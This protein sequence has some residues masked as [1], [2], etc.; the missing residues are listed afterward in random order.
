MQDVT[1]N[2]YSLYKCG[3]PVPVLYGM[4][5]FGTMR[6]NPILAVDLLGKQTDKK[7]IG[8]FRNG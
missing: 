1:R 6:P 2:T 7:P 8:K 4:S 5:D 3:T